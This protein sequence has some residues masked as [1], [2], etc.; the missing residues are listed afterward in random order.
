MLPTQSII[1][2][3]NA[4]HQN[5]MNHFNGAVES[6]IAAGKLLLQVKAS[7]PHGAW[8]TWL[9]TNIGVSE[10]QAQRYMAAAKG[11]HVPRLLESDKTDTMSVLQTTA[12]SKGIWKNGKWEPEPGS[13]YLFKEDEGTYW[14]SPSTLSDS[15]F[16]VCKH[17][18][19]PRM[20][21]DGFHRRYTIFSTVIDP[22][23][24]S[25]FYVGTTTPLGAFGV[26]GVLKSYGLKDIENSLIIGKPA[27]YRYERPFGEQSPENWYWGNNGEWDDREAY[28]DSIL[29]S[30]ANHA[31][32]N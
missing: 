32:S 4:H 15:Y 27:K 31:Q 2:Q 30:M 29:K 18:H 14:V 19:G 12:R 25:K 8:T 11:K 20:S 28:V 13:T 10:R 5:A 23:L 26:D 6:A 7:L 9:N 3:I 22:D 24:T 1:N 21:T 17:Y 16:H